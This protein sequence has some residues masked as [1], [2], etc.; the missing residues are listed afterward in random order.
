MVT[1]PWEF[2]TTPEELAPM[3]MRTETKQ[4]KV[5]KEKSTNTS[6]PGS[7]FSIYLKERQEGRMEKKKEKKTKKQTRG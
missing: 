6:R 4:H 7:N 2:R 3:L 5:S 1:F